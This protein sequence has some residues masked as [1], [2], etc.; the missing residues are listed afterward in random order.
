MLPCSV[1][2]CGN[3]VRSLGLCQSHYYRQR[4][5]GD[6]LGGRTAPGKPTI[7]L[8]D[9][10]MKYNGTDCLIWPFGRGRGGY[11]KIWSDGQMRIVSRIVC[12]QANGEPI[13]PT[14]QAAHSCGHGQYGC[15]AKA[16]LSWKT[17]AG[18]QADRVGH[19]TH[20]RGE[21]QYSAKLTERNVREI[22]RLRGR[23]TQSSLAARF[24]VTYQTVS[25]IQL[26][27]KWAWMSEC[28]PVED[29]AR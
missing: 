18:N 24:G 6:P 10:V 22:R 5:H 29:G 27:K 23:E 15:V 9:V 16:H 13:D 12:E 17:V 1:D 25:D 19:G 8:R 3:E 7:Y 14:F 26:R 11:G 4:R 28:A 20:S 21:R 2:K